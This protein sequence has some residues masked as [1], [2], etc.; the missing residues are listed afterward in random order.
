MSK[1]QLNAIYGLV[2]NYYNAIT[3]ANIQYIYN[4]QYNCNNSC[5]CLSYMY[6]PVLKPHTK[7]MVMKKIN[8]DALKLNTMKLMILELLKYVYS[9]ASID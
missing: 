4:Y 2:V 3:V 5:C 1:F 9:N 8:V 6:V 7:N